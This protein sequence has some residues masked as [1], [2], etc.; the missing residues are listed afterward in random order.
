MNIQKYRRFTTWGL[1]IAA[2][3]FIVLAVG[4]FFLDIK[5]IRDPVL[6]KDSYLR[7]FLLIMVLLFALLIMRGT[8][9]LLALHFN[10]EALK[11]FSLLPDLGIY[12]ET[13]AKHYSPEQKIKHAVLL[14][15]GFGSS[16]Q[17]FNHLTESLELMQIPYYAPNITGFGLNTLQLL[18]N[19]RYQDWFRKALDSFDN[20][21]MFCEKVS[22]IGHSMGGVLATFVAQQRNVY[23]LILSGPGFFSSK[24]DRYYQKILLTPVLSQIFRCLTPY[25]PKPRRKNRNSISDLL[26]KNA[27]KSMF[28]YL[29]LPINA[30]VEV[31]KEQNKVDISKAFYQSLT[32]IYGLHDVTVDNQKTLHYLREHKISFHEFCLTNSAHNVFEDFE[33]NRACEIVI[34]ILQK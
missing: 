16:P 3:V 14:L 6:L 28:R 19:V 18:N 32:I 4:V 17:E 12:T 31:F 27:S 29:A 30:V 21:N 13:L 5:I 2:L 1:V 11:Q 15:H 20:L 8:I 33:K 22:V 34:N 25:L 23:H 10:A 9:E 24:Q 7:I 26:D